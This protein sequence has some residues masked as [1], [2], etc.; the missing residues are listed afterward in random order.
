[1]N[2]KTK[3]GSLPLVPARATG[4]WPFARSS[5]TPSTGAGPRNAPGWIPNPRRKPLLGLKMVPVLAVMFLCVNLLPVAAADGPS[6]SGLLDIKTGG[7]MTNSGEALSGFDVYAALRLQER[8]KDTVTFYTAFNVQSASGMFAPPA[9]GEVALFETE[10]LYLRW[11]EDTWGIDAGLMPLH[12]GY[13]QAFAP[14]DFLIKKNPAVLDARPRGIIG[15]A[16]TQYPHDNVKLTEFAVFPPGVLP[17]GWEDHHFGAAFES[18]FAAASFEALY[19]FQTVSDSGQYGVYYFGGSLKLEAGIGLLAD[20]LYR[21][22]PAGT[23]DHEGLALSAGADYTFGKLYMLAEYLYNGINSASNRTAGGMFAARNLLAATFRYTISD[24]TGITAQGL[25]SIDGRSFLPS[26]V[27]SHDLM[28][29]F[30]LT[31][32]AQVPLD[33]AGNDPP[34]ELGPEATGQRFSLVTGVRLRI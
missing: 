31:V 14:S 29:G 34:G 18:H 21:Y 27:F 6:F 25:W 17:G 20:T 11:A 4:R 32:S 26:L 5:T 28:Q 22:D 9:G 33:L 1:M 13:G 7:G 30:T 16:F 15:A 23:F 2:T 24:L 12:F 19:A 3:G 10:R 8:V